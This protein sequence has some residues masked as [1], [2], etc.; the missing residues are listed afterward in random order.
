MPTEDGAPYRR[1][2]RAAA[3]RSHEEGVYHK[4]LCHAYGASETVLGNVARWQSRPV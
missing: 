4:L 2:H 1:E 3:L